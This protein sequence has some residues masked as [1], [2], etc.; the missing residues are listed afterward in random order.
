MP[1]N[2][3]SPIKDG[4]KAGAIRRA[5]MLGSIVAIGTPALVLA[6]TRPSAHVPATPSSSHP[7]RSAYAMPMITTPDGT[8][9]YY[10]DW[11]A[12]RPVLFS[13]GWPLNGDVWD[14]QMVFLGSV[15]SA[16]EW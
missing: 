6:Q 1:H 14:E 15:R 8:R 9:L 7:Q 5:V 4:E 3:R 11:G 10:K 16:L 13:H 2:T 12:G